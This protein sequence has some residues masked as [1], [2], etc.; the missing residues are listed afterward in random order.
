MGAAHEVL[1]M[2]SVPLPTV[3][4]RRLRL[5]LPTSADRADF[6]ALARRSRKLHRGLVT[7]PT[8]PARFDLWL[9]NVRTPTCIA[10]LLRRRSDGS[11][12]GS[13]ELS[14]IARGRFQSAYLGYWI[15]ASFARQGYMTEGLELALRYAFAQLHLHRLEANLQPQNVASRALVKRLGFRREGYSPRYLKLGGRWRDHERW[16]ILAEDWRATH[17]LRGRPALVTRRPRGNA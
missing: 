6:L 7:P 16:A 15:G 14:Q 1:G 3:R 11:L 8:T 9:A 17:R 4:G 5:T 2:D 12:L 13:L 10:L